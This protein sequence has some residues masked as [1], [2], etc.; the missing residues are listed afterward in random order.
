MSEES[1]TPF[2]ARHFSGPN[3]RTFQKVQKAWSAVQRKDKELKGSSNGIVG[4]YHKWLKARMQ[5]ITWLPKLKFSNEEEA[6][7]P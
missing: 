7:T 5:E 1:V 6:E 2:I 4:G 3:A